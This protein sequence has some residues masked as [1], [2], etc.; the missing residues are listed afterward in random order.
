MSLSPLSIDLAMGE[1]LTLSGPSGCGKTSL[2]KVLAGLQP[3]QS[4]EIQ[5]QQQRV[6]GNNLM[7]W[8][9]QCCY[10]PQEPILGAETISGVLRLPWALKAESTP[11][12]NDER[13]CSVLCDLGLAHHLD[14]DVRTLSG[15]EKQ[16]LAIARAMLLAR[17]IWLLDEPTSALDPKSRDNVITLLSQLSVIMVSISHDPVWAASADQT[18]DM[19]IQDE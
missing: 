9:K 8:R 17:P 13:C 4:G 6:T 7:W 12:P 1:H 18:Y 15:G 16:R 2:L 5:W 19:G 3:A 10:L 14:T 11:Q